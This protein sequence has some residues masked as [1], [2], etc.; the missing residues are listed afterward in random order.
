[1]AQRDVL[2]VGGAGVDTIVRVP[3]LPLARADS[4]VV[5]PIED[6]PGHTGNGVALGC[7]ALGLT[8]AL[9]DFIGDD[10]QGRL[11]TETYRRRGL[12][13]HGVTSPSG[14]RRSVNLVD[15]AGRRMAL[16][17]PRTPPELRLPRDVALPHLRAA[18]HV[19]LTIM[20]WARH[21]YD[22]LDALGTPVSTD[23]HDWDGRSDHH[24]DFAYRSHIVLVSAAALAGRHA[25]LLAHVLDRGRA[26]VAVATAGADGSY[27]LTPDRDEPVHVP[28]ATPDGPVVDCNGAGDAYAAA[29]LYGHLSGADW[30]ECAR[31]GAI[32]GAHACTGHGATGRLID[33]AALEARRAA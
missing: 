30:V 1:M 16:Y 14:T 31:L 7:H 10:P 8:T 6:H 3:G 25:E 18:R 19:H 26:Q 28:A 12:P 27:V 5:P 9:L 15:P 32:A 11:L 13:F 17:D 29:F 21:L 20:N 4:V 23:L 2:V 22:D 33:R 24:R